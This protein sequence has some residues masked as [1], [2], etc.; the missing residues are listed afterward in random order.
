MA[1]S[2]YNRLPP[3][4]KNEVQNYTGKINLHYKLFLCRQ[5]VNTHLNSDVHKHPDQ[6]QQN[7]D[8]TYICSNPRDA[9]QQLNAQPMRRPCLRL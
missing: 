1:K 9:G 5:Y 2:F 6:E 4:T 8:H 3:D 7:V